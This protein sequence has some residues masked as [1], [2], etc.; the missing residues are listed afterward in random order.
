MEAERLHLNILE[1]LHQQL[2]ECVSVGGIS[3]T[4][5]RAELGG[6]QPTTHNDP[7]RQEAS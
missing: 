2:R 1:E 7:G 3:G 5:E 6:E 4:A